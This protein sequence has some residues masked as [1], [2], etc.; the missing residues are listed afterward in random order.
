M[1]L[2]ILQG[3]GKVVAGCERVEGLGREGSKLLDWLCG[4]GW[5]YALFRCSPFDECMRVCCWVRQ[6][7]L[8]MVLNVPI[9]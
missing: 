3:C 7:L 1:R 9:G 8:V 6:C 2:L 5:V 4:G